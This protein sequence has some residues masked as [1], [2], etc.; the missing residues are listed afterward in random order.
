MVTELQGVLVKKTAFNL[1]YEIGSNDP[2]LIATRAD[3]SMVIDSEEG[4]S[5][6]FHRWN[7]GK[8]RYFHFSGSEF[9]L[10]VDF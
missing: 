4:G 10:C 8:D 9:S 1:T 5:G 2:G 3:A 7:S 6:L